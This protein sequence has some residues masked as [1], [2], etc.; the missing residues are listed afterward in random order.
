MSAFTQAIDR[1]WDSDDWRLEA[2]INHYGFS[3]RD[4]ESCKSELGGDRH[5]VFAV[6]KHRITGIEVL[7]VCTDCLMYIANG[8]EPENWED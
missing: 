3:W 2:G 7:S 1:Q 5:E 4:C 8:D 6:P